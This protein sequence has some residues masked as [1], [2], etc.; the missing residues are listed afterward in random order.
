MGGPENRGRPGS[1]RS[2]R[3]GASPIQATAIR[4]KAAPIDVRV[5]LQKIIDETGTLGIAGE[6]DPVAVDGRGSAEI[7]LQ[8]LMDQAGVVRVPT[9]RAV[10]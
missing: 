1:H 7:A 10:D 9:P 8:Q 6:H 4:V 5:T 2:W 3:P